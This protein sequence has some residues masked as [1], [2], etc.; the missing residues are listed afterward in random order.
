MLILIL[1]I[2]TAVPVNFDYVKDKSHIDVSIRTET[3]KNISIVNN[4]FFFQVPRTDVSRTSRVSSGPS[5]I[6]ASSSV[7]E[8]FT[9]SFGTRVSRTSRISFNPS[10]IQIS[11]TSNFSTRS[12]RIGATSAFNLSP[13]V[14]FK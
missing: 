6:H 2:A 7:R 12:S 1:A 9:T 5:G 14:F 8:S 10:N 4:R 3:G 11:R 13:S